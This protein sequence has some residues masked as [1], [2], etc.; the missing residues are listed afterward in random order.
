MTKIT[1]RLFIRSDKEETYRNWKELT[2]TEKKY[3]S[4]CLIREAA[5]AG[6]FRKEMTT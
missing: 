2:E 3:I 1:G 6:G 4:E 5:H